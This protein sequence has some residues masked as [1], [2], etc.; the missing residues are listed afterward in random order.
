M[1][2]RGPT[3]HVFVQILGSV[4]NILQQVQ[5]PSHRASVPTMFTSPPIPGSELK[6]F[7]D[8]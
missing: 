8:G 3:N 2:K 6:T 5:I 4:E 1:M 7:E